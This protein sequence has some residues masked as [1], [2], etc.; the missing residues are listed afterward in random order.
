MQEIKL[1]GLNEIIYYEVTPSGLPVYMWKNDKKSNYYLSLAVKYG[2]LHTD[3]T[4]DGVKIHSPK[5]IAHYL[6]HLKFNEDDKTNANDFFE[7]TGTSSNAFTTFE[8]TNYE[9]IGTDNFLENLNHLLD[10]VYNPY[11]TQ[12]LLNKERGIISEEIKMG[13]DNPYNKLYYEFFKNVFHNYNYRYEVAGTVDD[14]KEITLKDIIETYNNFYHPENMFLVITGNFNPYEAIEI[15]NNNLSNKDFPAFSKVEIINGVEPKSVC[16][17]EKTLYE[18]VE[19]PKVKIGLKLKKNVFKD[20]NDIKIYIALS[21]LLRTNFGSTSDFREFLLTNRL[22]ESI[23]TTREIYND[24]VVIGITFESKC[25][26]EAIKV[27][28]EKLKNMEIDELS[29][30]RRC[31]ANIANLVLE[32]DNVIAVNNSIQSNIIQYGKIID[33]MK[34]IY[35]NFDYNSLND[36]LKKIKIE[37][38]NLTIL[39]L[40]PKND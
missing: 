21:I 33:D 15:V 24:Y 8:Y 7:K 10:Y 37:K 1:K 29:I 12:K 16:T 25:P 19:I 2:S 20:Y 18:N 6:E 4:K 3:Y 39:K 34:E 27:I 13:L 5:G 30:D 28:T 32:F 31:K 38:N 36:I 9:V 40:L 22:V 23:S 35:E 26:S 11:F 14:I 17:S